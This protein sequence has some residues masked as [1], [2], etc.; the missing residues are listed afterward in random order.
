MP[1]RLVRRP[2]L[3]PRLFAKPLGMLYLGCM[4]KFARFFVTVLGALLLAGCMFEEP[5][6]TGGF[7]ELPDSLGGVWVAPGKADDP[8]GDSYGVLAPIDAQRWLL[9]YPAGQAEKT[10][11]YEVQARRLGEGRD[12]LQLR[13]IASFAGGLP[14]AGEGK[15]TLVLCNRI[16]GNR[17]EVR[18]IDA[19]GPLKGKKAPEARKMLEAP[20]ADWNAM[21]VREPMV[22]RL[23]PQK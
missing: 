1:R 19:E 10:V 18:L 13:T 21:F 8:R 5:V 6:L 7:S 15:Y 2:Q 22:F 16:A 9:A 17:L 11:Y 3:G 23:L 4:P 20:D 14:D 12:L